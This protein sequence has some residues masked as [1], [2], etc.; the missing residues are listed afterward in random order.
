MKTLFMALFECYNIPKLL[1]RV[2][3]MFNEGKVLKEDIDFDYAIVFKVKV[4]VWQQ[5][6]I[7]DFGGIIEDYNK[8]TVKINGTYFMRNACEFRVR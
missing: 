1:V 2:S 3:S 5:D 7:L 4:I 8:D 6:E